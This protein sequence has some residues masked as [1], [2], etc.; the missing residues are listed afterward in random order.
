MKA[1]CI[2]VLVYIFIFIEVYGL[3]E[4]TSVIRG[5]ITDIEGNSL[6]GAGVTIENTFLG[7]HSAADGYYR[8]DG[9]KDGNYNLRISFIGYEPEL[10]SIDLEGEA[11]ANVSLVQKSF[12]AGE[13]IVNATRAGSRSPLAYTSLENEILSKQNSGHD[14]PYLLS[15]TPSLVETSEA[16]N[17]IG[18]TNL[19]IRGTDASRINVTMDGIPLNDPE[20]QQ[21]FW[22]DIPDLASSV[23]N[24]QVQ[25]GAGTSTNGA[26][27]FGA[28]VNMQTGNPGNDPFA[29]ISTSL[30]S[31]NTSRKM[32]A[33]GSG[34]LAGKFAFQIR[35]SDLKSDGYIDRTGSDH[36]SAFINGAFRTARSFL[37]ANIFLGQE[38]TG[39]G[40]WG[41]PP[42]I[43]PVNRKYNPAGEYTDE[44]NVVQYYDNESDNYNQNHY[45]LFYGLKLNNSLSLST[46]FHYTSGE[47]YYEEFKEDRD[48]SDYGLPDIITGESIISQSDLIRRKWMDNDFYGLVYSVKYK[49]DKLSATFGG[50]GNYYSGDHYGRIIWMSNPGNIPK[51][52]QWY[53]NNGKKGEVS[54]YAKAD[55][56]L[57][58]KL[59]LFADLQFRFIDY[60]MDGND[61]D[62]KDLGQRHHYAFL[63]PKAGLFYSI[64]Q[65]QDAY[66]SFSV[67]NRE[68]TRAD[69]KEAAGDP[70]AVPQP[71]ILYDTELGYK[72]RKE[73]YSA[74]INLYAMLYNDQLVPT[75][76][77][78]ST[79][80]PIMTNVKKSRRL[81]IELSA[82]LRPADFFD[83]NLNLTLSSNKIPDFIEYY[84]DYNTS[85][86]SEEYRSMNLGTVDIAYSP[87]ATG[88]SDLNFK[89]L[90]NTELHLI[91][92]Y[93]GEQYFDN[94][95]N[96][97]RMID[98]YF[99]NN[100]RIDF[101]PS[102]RGLKNAGFQL[103]I[104]N[105]LNHRYESNA[106]GGNWF[107]DGVE[108]T[109]SYFFPQAGINFMVKAE[110]AF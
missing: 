76:E 87:S 56:V 98:P 82:G 29:K 14:I 96:S 100:L 3:Q 2:L 77:L 90:K 45:Q 92:K 24:I 84:I 19:R 44:N 34:L 50:G 1:K 103:F 27:A 99:V 11:V 69:F 80:Y 73:R 62:L 4:R 70:D 95:M 86:W 9:L 7:T 89:I 43:L 110:L 10:V 33:A 38:H 101:N 105:I 13:V 59:S 6:S 107:E 47:G 25:R 97:E 81:G 57:N 65:N 35:L 94:T 61:D 40:W 42:E 37:K 64:D 60:R 26:G 53:L 36:Q 63:N 31:F 106:Y 55:Y 108:K 93:V 83:W 30:G 23:D 17:G 102:I 21:V 85:D 68:P 32:I 28:T 16:G 75:G 49:T 5:R 79:G 46:A 58:E 66:L 12:L 52:H 41:V 67:A 88:T 15:L 71:E 78:S 74:A 109:W 8:I 39:I 91:S 18:Y 20:S 54:T 72:L 48:L 51:D 22:V 104:N